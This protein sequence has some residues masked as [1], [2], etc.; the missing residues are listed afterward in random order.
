MRCIL[1][2]K[3]VKNKGKISI[4]FLA[5]LR[6]SANLSL[7]ELARLADTSRSTISR[8]ENNEVPQPFK[9]S[10]RKLIISLAELLCTTKT[11]TERYLNLAG[12]ER[13]LLTEAEEIQLG[14]VPRI[15]KG[16]PDELAD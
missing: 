15:P 13:S 16:T 7:E 6:S 10:I 9:G 8:L 5:N 14:F 4:A 1:Y 12:I 3:R 2:V 11:G